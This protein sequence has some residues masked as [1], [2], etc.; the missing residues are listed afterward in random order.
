MGQCAQIDYVAVGRCA[1]MWWCVLWASAQSLLFAM[2]I[3]CRIIGQCA[4]SHEFHSKACCI[5]IRNIEAKAKAYT[6]HA[7]GPSWLG[8]KIDSAQWAIVQY[9][10]AVGYEAGAQ[11][12]SSDKKTRG[13]KSRETVSL[14]TLKARKKL[15]QRLKLFKSPAPSVPVSL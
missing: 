8:T 15:K 13:I 9:E 11:L 7:W 1:R 14:R 4:E 12:E 2:G 3:L 10:T 5:L 6:I